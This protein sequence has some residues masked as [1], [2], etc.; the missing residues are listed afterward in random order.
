MLS[1]AHCHLEMLVDGYERPEQV[2]EIVERAQ[3][4]GVAIII[5][6]GIDLENSRGAVSIANTYESVYCVVGVHPWWVK[7]K[8]S[9]ETAGALKEMALNNKKVVG[10]GEA[11]LDFIQNP[12]HREEQIQVL[13]RLIRLAREVGLP[14]N[15]HARDPQETLRVLK[16]EGAREVG[17][18]LHGFQGDDTS[19]HGFMDLGFY[20]SLGHFPF[21]P[22]REQ[23]QEVI[24]RL[25]LDRIVLE[26]DSP[27][28][29]KP[30][31]RGEPALVR[32]VAEKV[33][34]LRGTT[35]EEL[36]NATLAN[37]KHL[38]HARMR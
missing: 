3:A 6:C 38:F 21:H 9:E 7:E 8:L 1:D 23:S 15:L 10:I 25:P 26:T 34:K 20:L 22:G 19:A 12:D 33:A 16:E 28:G 5:T 17:G 35:V 32:T 31:E 11:G 24:K 36:S 29:P 2:R 30:G 14:L 13:R 37:L 27:G 4:A 18:L